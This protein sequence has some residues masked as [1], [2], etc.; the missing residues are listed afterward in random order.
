MLQKVEQRIKRQ[1]YRFNIPKPFPNRNVK[2]YNCSPQHIRQ[3][4]LTAEER[5]DYVGLEI[6]DYT[7]WALQR[8][9][10]REDFTYLKILEYSNKYRWIVDKEKVSYK[11][12]SIHRKISEH[13]LG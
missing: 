3:A 13:W 1:P 12:F 2:V 4:K 10:E 11:K 6:A 5:R 7:L 8:G 9:I